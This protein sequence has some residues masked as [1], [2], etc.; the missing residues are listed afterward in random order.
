MIDIES[1]DDPNASSFFLFKRIG[2]YLYTGLLLRRLGSQFRI[3]GYKVS[4]NKAEPLVKA[5]TTSDS[6]T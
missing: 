1:S 4:F 3:K 5:S 2:K 6:D